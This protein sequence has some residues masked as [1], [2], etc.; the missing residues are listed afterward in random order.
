MTPE[1]LAAPV[2]QQE[3][4]NLLSGTSGHP[5]HDV[6][7]RMAFQV[8]VLRAEL[9]RYKK[10]FHAAHDCGDDCLGGCCYL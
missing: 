6:A 10:A 7:R 8:D 9:V 3:M 4:G 1:E 2:T 5:L